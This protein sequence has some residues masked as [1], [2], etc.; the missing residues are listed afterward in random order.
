MPCYSVW[1]W[2]PVSCKPLQKPSSP[3]SR[4]ARCPIGCFFVLI[5]A[6]RFACDTVLPL[7]VRDVF[8]WNSTAAGLV[9]IC[10][11]VPGF[12]SPLVGILSDRYGAKWPAVVGFA[13]SIPLLVSL[14]FVTQNTLNDKVLL[15]AL[16]ALLGVTIL[17]LANTPLMAAMTYAIDDKEARR[18]GMWGEKGVYGIAYGLWTTCFALGGTIGS[19]MAGYINAGPG[20]GTLTWS[21]AVWCSAGVVVCF[22]LGPAPG[23]RT[24]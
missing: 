13:L 11:M 8:H 20:W 19:L 10:I 2:K 12:L 9:F 6:G 3:V 4:P 7:F 22:G 1:W 14:R 17:A 24:Q 18:P 23:R 5:A 21:L 16:L 15:C